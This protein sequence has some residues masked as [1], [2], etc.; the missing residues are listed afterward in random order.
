MAEKIRVLRLIEYTYSSAAVMERDMARWQTS[1]NHGNVRVRSTALPPTVLRELEPP[2]STTRELLE[3][4]R[5]ALAFLYGGT[6]PD[7][8]T[9]PED[10][11]ACE[12]MHALYRAA[13]E[14][15]EETPIPVPP[16]DS[17]ARIAD[18]Y[19]GRGGW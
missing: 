11:A 13:G 9:K 6:T 4:A 18:H 5:K 7:Q 16:G 12:A 8:Y 10:I 14:E 17:E 1:G 19:P 2:E 15:E 3:Q